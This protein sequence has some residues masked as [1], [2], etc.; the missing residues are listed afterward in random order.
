[1]TPVQRRSVGD[2][3]DDLAGRTPDPAAGVAAALMVASAAALV[4]M[5]ARFSDGRLGD[6]AAAAD[7]LRADVLRLADEDGVAYHGVLETL[8]L[9]RGTAQ[10]AEQ[11]TSAL[12]AASEVPLRIGE[13]AAEVT[14]M[15]CRLTGDGNPN[16]AGDA[17]TAAALA[18]AVTHAV[19]RM[20]E[21][22][23]RLGKLDHD[24]LRRADR[25]VERAE[26]APTTG[27]DP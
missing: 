5:A 26:K 18:A 14:E 8:Q 23:V 27:G 11:L 3:L 25:L 4:A 7:R 6:L 22:K 9:P 10:R 24:L 15:A 21:A 16:L 12:Q 2:F 13:A 1:M 19:G 20:V 17:D